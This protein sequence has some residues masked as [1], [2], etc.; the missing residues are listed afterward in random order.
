MQ[1]LEEKHVL[2]SAASRRRRLIG[3]HKRRFRKPSSEAAQHKSPRKNHNYNQ[4]HT[5]KDFHRPDALSRM[6]ES[7]TCFQNVLSERCVS[8][9][10]TF[11]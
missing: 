4:E 7:G 6:R 11:G 2:E 3:A 10:A 1:G 8:P 9:E 5:Q